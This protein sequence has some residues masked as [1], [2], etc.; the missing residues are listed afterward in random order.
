MNLHG[1][2][3]EGDQIPPP[4]AFLRKQTRSRVSNGSIQILIGPWDPV[5]DGWAYARWSESPASTPGGQLGCGHHWQ[6]PGSFRTS[7]CAVRCMLVA[8]SPEGDFG[9]ANGWQ[10]HVLETPLRKGPGV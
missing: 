6:L 5:Q 10:A 3:R 8:A 1:F 9:D 7:V 2:P 4:C